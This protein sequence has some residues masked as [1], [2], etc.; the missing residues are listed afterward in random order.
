MRFVSKV[1][2]EGILGE[3][4][5]QSISLFGYSM[6]YGQADR[7]LRKAEERE[8]ARKNYMGYFELCRTAAFNH[9]SPNAR[10]ARIL[11]PYD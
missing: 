1:R 7:D 9:P 3:V 10:F 4:P 6:I 11:S 2:L 8:I 5:K